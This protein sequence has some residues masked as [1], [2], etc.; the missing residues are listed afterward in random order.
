MTSTGRY[1]KQSTTTISRISDPLEIG[2]GGSSG[3]GSGRQETPARGS[4][5]CICEG[6]SGVDMGRM[7]AEAGAAE[8]ISCGFSRCETTVSVDG[9]RALARDEIFDL[10][11]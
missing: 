1:A 4:S 5:G 2:W 3:V 7:I 9:P 11:F 6:G 10:R 8:K